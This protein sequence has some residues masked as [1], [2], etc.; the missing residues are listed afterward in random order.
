ME[1]IR[2]EIGN[3]TTFTSADLAVL[4]DVLR[5]TYTRWVGG[6]VVYQVCW[7]VVGWLVYQVVGVLAGDLPGG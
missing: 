7:W 4:R 1:G 2:E 3:M 6:W 5:K